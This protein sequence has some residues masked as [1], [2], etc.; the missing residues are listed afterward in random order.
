ML[1]EE[2]ILKIYDTH[3]KELLAYIYRL[4]NNTSSAEDILHD[5][6]IN[7][8]NYNKKK[9]ITEPRAFLYKTA[10]NLSVNFLK[11]SSKLIMTDTDELDV[12]SSNQSTNIEEN[13]IA[14]DLQI[15]INELLTACDAVSRSI[16]ILK[17]E[18]GFSTTEIANKIGQSERTVRRKLQKITE[19][20]HTELKKGNYL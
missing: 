17:K 11:K 4:I 10:H 5:C 20:L 9:E 7:F 18:N 14:N 8:L 12:K 13:A 1:N 15:K 6:F 16:F 3:K 2:Q 19:F